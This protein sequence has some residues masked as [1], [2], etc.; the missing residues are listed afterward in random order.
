MFFYN[1]IVIPTLGSLV[2][3]YILIVTKRHINSMSE[4]NEE[5]LIEYKNII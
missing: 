3:G 4:L 5:E 2:D 1:F